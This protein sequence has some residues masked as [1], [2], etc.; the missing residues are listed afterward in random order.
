MDAHTLDLL[1]VRQSPASCWR[2]MPARPWVPISPGRLSHRGDVAK[3]RI[4]LTL[5]S[6][7]VEALDGEAR[8]RHS[9]ACTTFACLFVV[10]LPSAPC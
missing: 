3:V 10:L 6:E 5:V 2:N 4:G 8:H 7:M 1:E 9:V